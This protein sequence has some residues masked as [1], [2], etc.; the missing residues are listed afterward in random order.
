MTLITRG[1]QSL[2]RWAAAPRGSLASHPHAHS[3]HARS[4]LSTSSSSIHTG[5]PAAAVAAKAAPG[6]L[7]R[8]IIARL[9]PIPA[10]IRS[11]APAHARSLHSSRLA[12][13]APSLPFTARASLRT[14][15]LFIPR[16][17]VVVSRSTTQ[18]GL[19]HARTFCSGRPLFQNLV[20]NV[21]I[22]GRAMWEAD[23]ELKVK[24]DT[25]RKRFLSPQADEPKVRGEMLKPRNTSIQVSQPESNIQRDL[26]R[27]FP[28]PKF[29]VTTYL[30]VPLAPNSRAPLPHNSSLLASVEDHPLLPI[31]IIARLHSDHTIHSHRVTSLFR[32]L[33]QARVW[34]RG[35]HSES[36]GY[37]QDYRDEGA[38]QYIKLVFPGWTREDVKAVLG[39]AGE[40][41]C[42]I[43][44]VHHQ[45]LY[46]DDYESDSNATDS[47]PPSPTLLPSVAALSLALPTLDF[48]ASFMASLDSSE[49]TLS[50]STSPSALEYGSDS[51]EE[52]DVSDG[53]LHG[54][55]WVGGR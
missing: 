25:G 30:I 8:N 53:Y 44:T 31:P 29:T 6:L 18:V 39:T 49:L 19:G 52:S 34:D 42:D 16:G 54:F 15:T 46:D 20:Q 36:Y 5:T 7:I 45:S 9:L 35:V 37:P 24:K 33:D 48:S 2:K 14:P 10:P 1:V 51:D 23:W 17:P 47:P 43:Q 11:A 21:P 32:R 27:Y 22:A 28:A 40:G 26:E 41:W 55:S 38:V 3:P 50:S 12:L 4:P 13:P